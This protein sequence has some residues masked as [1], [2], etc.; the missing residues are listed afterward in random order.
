MPF[1]LLVPVVGVLSAVLFLG[2]PLSWRTV[3]GGVATLI[4]VG[5]IIVRRPQL[6]DPEVA[7]KTT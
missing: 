3:V 5:I 4:G 7:S 2:E 1:T 6:P